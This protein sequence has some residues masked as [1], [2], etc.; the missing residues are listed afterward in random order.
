[1]AATNLGRVQGAGFFYSSANSATTVA[2]NT[3]MPNNVSPL[4]GDTVVFSNGD[5]RQVQAIDSTNVSLGAATGSFQG[6]Q[7]EDPQIFS[8]T[9]T[10]STTKGNTSS[11]DTAAFYPSP[12]EVQV[13]DLVVDING[14]MGI[15]KS[16]YQDDDL[17]IQV[18]TIYVQGCS[19]MGHIL[20]CLLEARQTQQMRQMLKV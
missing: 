1:M 13:G 8:I 15:A 3:I 14:N 16:T 6:P 11:I 2:L 19:S 18:Q 17:F 12:L 9:L 20:R 4:V 10:M 5:I 7:G